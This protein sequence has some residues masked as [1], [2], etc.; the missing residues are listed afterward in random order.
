MGQPKKRSQISLDLD[1]DG[2]YKK[3]P[4]EQR[5]LSFADDLKYSE[6][7]LS[8][9]LNDLDSDGA[10]TKQIRTE[11]EEQAKKLKLVQEKH[12]AE[13][14]AFEFYKKEEVK[15]IKSEEVIPDEENEGKAIDITS[16]DL[17]S[18]GHYNNAIVAKVKK[19]QEGQQNS[20]KTRNVEHLLVRR[21][22]P[23]TP[24][25]ENKAFFKEYEAFN[26]KL[27]DDPF[28]N[29]RK[30]QYPRIMG[31]YFVY[32]HMADGG[33]AKICRGKYLGEHEIEN[34]ENILVIKMIKEE[35][36]K[37]KD[38]IQMFMD[39]IDV[40]YNFK[41]PNISAMYDYG[42]SK[43]NL[44]VAMEYIHGRDL[45]DIIND[46]NRAQKLIPIP[47]AVYIAMKMSEGLH[48]VHH[49]K[50]P[51][52]GDALHIVHRDI[53]PHN[54]MISYSGA[55]KVIDF[56]IAKSDS[57]KQKDE[58]GTV[59]GKINYFAPEYL[60]GK[61]INHR[62]DQFAVG[63]TLWEMLTG[64]R[65]FD[66]GEQVLTLKAIL[67]C[68]PDK[69]SKH[70]SGVDEKLDAIIMKS[71][72]KDPADRFFDMKTFAEVLGEYL[73][74]KYP[75]MNCQND[76]AAIT[77]AMYK[78]K[79]QKDMKLFGT[80]ASIALDGVKD[81]L[82][83]LKSYTK[84]LA[85]IEADTGGTNHRKEMMFDFGFD[86]EV[87]SVLNRKKFNEGL[88]LDLSSSRSRRKER[89]KAAREKQL[90]IASYLN[91]EIE[92]SK[93]RS[94][95]RKRNIKKGP[96][97]LSSL[98]DWFQRLIAVGVMVFIGVIG[99]RYATAPGW[100]E[101]YLEYTRLKKDE[102]KNEVEVDIHR[103]YRYPMEYRILKDIGY[104]F[105]E[106]V[107]GRKNATELEFLKFKYEKIMVNYIAPELGISFV[108]TI[109]IS[110]T[111]FE[112][113]E[114]LK[115]EKSLEGKRFKESM[116]FLKALSELK[117]AEKQKKE[118]EQIKREPAAFEKQ[119]VKPIEGNPIFDDLKK[120]AMELK[121]E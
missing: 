111:D 22:K 86:N 17:D 121:E 80:W 4:I 52:S 91:D 15:H 70:N 42:K 62:Y 2:K 104:I 92:K 53:S 77:Q 63:L 5:D 25:E 37:Q 69:A 46:L 76:L 103:M 35:F 115:Y 79:Y 95:K 36:S 47:I 78:S 8:I 118:I 112:E 59:K 58:E 107:V 10:F 64:K 23:K 96:S 87:I 106:K 100:E 74:E 109:Y 101:V 38:Y 116:D 68:D 40:A 75:E 11:N 3:E 43:E 48:Y 93:T 1:H 45:M 33:M 50:D 49:F 14:S 73:T 29:A 51:N 54:V 98:F 110:Q 65:T 113:R 56:G 32:D 9:N 13:D 114:N 26:K 117:E 57:S 44:F 71:L 102:V 99:F 81:T 83:K 18:K 55:V 16:L 27:V 41:H 24:E 34:K 61:D 7:T 20:G 94:V 90:A 105:Y 85:E 12:K 120:R 39:E 60:E 84:R 72:S 67:D 66:A 21:E 30:D 89:Q 28:F 82:E 19:Q 119:E 6:G 97:Q 88:Q 31:D 108:P